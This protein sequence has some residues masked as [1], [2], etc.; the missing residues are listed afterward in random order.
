MILTSRANIDAI[1]CANKD[2][3]LSTVPF[4]LMTLKEVNGKDV[5]VIEDTLTF[6][7]CPLCGGTLNQMESKP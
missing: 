5:L 6:F 4:A 2:C 7:H 3:Y 1:Y